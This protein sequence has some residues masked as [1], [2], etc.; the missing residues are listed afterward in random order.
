VWDFYA[1]KVAQSINSE[2][3]FLLLSAS[4]V[5]AINDAKVSSGFLVYLNSVQHPAA[6]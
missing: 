5:A 2:V 3:F 4:H 1:C 6:K